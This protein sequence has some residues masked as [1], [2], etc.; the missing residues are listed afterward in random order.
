M[1]ATVIKTNLLHFFKHDYYSYFT[2]QIM[3]ADIYIHMPLN[4]FAR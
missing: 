2:L 4:S 3:K 1:N